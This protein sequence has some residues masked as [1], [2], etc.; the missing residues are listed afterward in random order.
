[1]NTHQPILPTITIVVSNVSILRI[2]AMN[3][4]IGHTSILVNY[5]T[6]WSQLVTLIIAGKTKM[7]PTSTYPMWY[8]VIPLLCL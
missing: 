3:P 8:N 1:M 6:T 2:Q 4:S 5:Q 7:L